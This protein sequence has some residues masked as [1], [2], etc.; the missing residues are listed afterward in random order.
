MANRGILTAGAVL[1]A[2]QVS[3]AVAASKLDKCR[4]IA[5]PAA[6]LS[7]YDAISGRL[8]QETSEERV[9]RQT[10]QFGLSEQR[11]APEERKEVEHVSARISSVGGGRVTLDNG[12][13]WK[14]T[15][16]SG[17]LGWVREGQMATIRQGLFS[18]YR[19]TI[20][21]VTGKAVVVR[22]Q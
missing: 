11:K 14:V 12:M 20:D 17:L 2:L 7:C 10:R 8:E 19:M 1:V 5:D 9:E 22:T 15:D 18:G 3:P 6:R 13:V 21:G 16:G 4:Q